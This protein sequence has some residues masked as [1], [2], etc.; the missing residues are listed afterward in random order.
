MKHDVSIEAP[1]LENQVH[2]KVILIAKNLKLVVAGSL[3]VKAQFVSMFETTETVGKVSFKL[4]LPNALSRLHPV[5]RVSLLEQ[6]FEKDNHK[7]ILPRPS[8]SAWRLKS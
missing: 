5:F 4:K 2:A 7:D 1:D 6:R 8:L 3:K